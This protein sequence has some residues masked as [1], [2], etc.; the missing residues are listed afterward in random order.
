[1][2]RRTDMQAVGL[3]DLTPHYVET[4]RRWRDDVHRQCRRACEL[5]YDERFRRLWTLYLAYCEAGFA[6][7]RICDVQLLLAKPRL[8]SHRC[9]RERAVGAQQTAR[10][11][12]ER[13]INSLLDTVLDRT[14]VA[15]YT[16]LG[17]RIRS[18]GWS[19]SELQRMEGKVVL[20]T[21]A[22]SGLGLPPLRASR[23]WARP[24]GWSP[25]AQSARRAGAREDHRAV[26]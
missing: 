4:L 17:Y 11:L 21:G 14:V 1:M 7:R 12:A 13:M 15:G 19:A 5:G 26:R 18:R 10:P 24:S 6:E 2:A 20:I 3:E 9:S 25:G 8:A 22:S 16:S 23:V